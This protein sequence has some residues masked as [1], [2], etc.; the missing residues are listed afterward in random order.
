MHLRVIA[1]IGDLCPQRG[2]EDY[3]KRPEIPS[4]LNLDRQNRYIKGINDHSLTGVA[5]TRKFV[6][7]APYRVG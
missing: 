4:S 3:A 2:V 6:F 5:V 1:I 7:P